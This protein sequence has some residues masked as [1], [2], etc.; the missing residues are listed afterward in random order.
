[1]ILISWMGFFMAVI[2][3]SLVG[4][5]LNEVDDHDSI[6]EGGGFDDRG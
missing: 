1:M 6:A 3:G 4:D 5:S 2:R